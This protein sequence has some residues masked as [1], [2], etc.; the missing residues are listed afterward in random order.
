MTKVASGK[1][2]A[3][4]SINMLKSCGCFLHENTCVGVSL[5]FWVLQNFQ[6][7][8]FEEHLQT[9]ASENEF[10]KIIHIEK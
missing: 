5:S 9:A 1:C 6:S 3:K 8:Y 2:S 4:K 7:I 10:I